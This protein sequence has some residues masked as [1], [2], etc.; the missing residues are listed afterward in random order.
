M[1]AVAADTVARPTAPRRTITMALPLVVAVFAMVGGAVTAEIGTGVPWG[2]ISALGLLLALR[3]GKV[4]VDLIDRMILSAGV[5]GSTVLVVLVLPEAPPTLDVVTCLDFAGAWAPAGIGFALV[6]FRRGGSPTQVFNT[7]LATL[8]AAGFALPAAQAF[9]VLQPLDTLRRGLESDFGRADYMT[10]ALVVGAIGIAAFLAALTRLPNLATMTTIVVFT[11]F[12]AATVGFSIGALIEGIAKIVNVPNVWPPDFAWA[13]GD[14]TWWWLPTWEFGA[15]LRANPLVETLR[16]GT[17]ATVL[18]CVV[19]LPLAFFA[20]TLTTINRPVYLVSKGFMNVTRTVPDLFWAVILVE[21]VGFG[22]FAGAIALTIFAMAIMS[23]LLSETIDGA[24]P[25]P[26]E[27]A[28]ATGSRHSPAV[29]SSVL[30][31][32]MPNYVAYAL[33]IFE[34]TIRAS[35]VV[36]F[37]GAGGIGRVLETQRGFYRY[38]RIFAIII[39]IIVVVSVLEQISVYLRR[40]LV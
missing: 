20:S 4:A 37:V 18:G 14:G 8:I 3:L 35:F 16:M 26:L 24:E 5:V 23:K 40:R 6:V 38:D 22:P 28:K 15:P 30:P 17:T 36:G 19:A 13:I 39:V 27:A 2:V 29:R 10:I 31:Q 32:V 33:Y 25:G 1:T 34:L 21:S 12:A 7:A 11:F 9:G